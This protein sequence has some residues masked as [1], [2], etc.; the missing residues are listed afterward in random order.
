M[1][2]KV[3]F[4][5]PN[6]SF[7]PSSLF[8]HFVYL[9]EIA[10]YTRRF[11]EVEVF[12]LSVEPR[13]RNELIGLIE[14]S[15]YVIVPTEVYNIHQGV[16]I[17]KLAKQL[18]GPKVVTYGTVAAMNPSILSPYFDAVIQ[19]EF[20]EKAIETMILS[21]EVF[22]KNLNE[23][24]YSRSEVLPNNEWG[25]PALDL[26]PLDRYL[27]IVPGQLEIRVQR[28]CR[29]NCSF[30]AE[31][32]RV[33]NRAV[34]HRHP[35]DI[36][37]FL[38]KNEGFKFYIDAATFTQD[39]SWALDVCAQLSKIKP[40][41][42]WRTVT[43]VDRVDGEIAEALANA[44]CYKVGLGVESLSK[45]VQK[46]VKKIIGEK[47]IRTSVDLLRRNGI[48]PRLFFILG[49][50][51]QTKEDIVH[52]QNFIGEL[53]VES[54]W[55]EYVPLGEVP[56]FKSLKDFERFNRGALLMHK[57]PNLNEED[58]INLLRIER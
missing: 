6:E 45:D 11:A 22:Q 20:W 53:G 48:I 36:A 29:G 8:K 35:Q 34:F 49:L 32:Y 19:R 3:K 50:P 16:N 31:P 56:N 37:S 17:A 55:K 27:N 38:E 28:G 40:S 30:C 46:E 10:D 39:K 47:E 1:V 5:W 57:I 41:R 18:K 54:R 58:Y 21:P 15:D 14:K 44:G 7:L 43:R 4:I 23:R 25:F 2:K 42:I 12:D 9:G 26:I 33:P 51:G 13:T 24:V 52:T